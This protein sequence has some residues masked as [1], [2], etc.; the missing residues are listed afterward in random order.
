MG[1]RK[2]VFAIAI[3]VAV[4]AAALIWRLRSDPLR[5]LVKLVGQRRVTEAR[6]SGGFD[7]AP[8][9]RTAIRA[10]IATR[11][12]SAPRVRGEEQTRASVSHGRSPND[13]HAA[14]MATLLFGDRRRAVTRFEQLA[15]ENPGDPQ[16]W[17]DLAAAR[18][19]A[20]VEASDASLVAA[21]LAAA[22]AALRLDSAQPEA[23]FNR[24]VAIEHLGIREEARK[25]WMRFLAVDGTSPWAAEAQERIRRTPPIPFFLVDL[26]VHYDRL[27][28][29]AAFAHK[30]ARE[31]PEET[32]L[33]SE[34][35]ILADWAAAAAAG[36]EEAAE[37][38]LG[39]AREFGRE[40]ARNRGD[41]MV[42][43]AVRAVEDADDGQRQHLIRGHTLFR[44]GQN[45][46]K[47][48]R[49]A[50]AQKILER[51]ADDL[52]QGGSP[53]RL[54]A[55]F[56]LAHTFDALGNVAEARRRELKLLADA[57][58]EF[59]AHRA[60]LLWYLGI[61]Y[62]SDGDFG[63]A[64]DVLGESVTIFDDLGEADYAAAVR[65]LM[66]E[67][68]D[69]NGNP[70]EA[71]QQH[72]VSL[73]GVGRLI[74]PRL[75]TALQNV[76]RGAMMRKD[77]PVAL[78]FLH[79]AGEM[80]V[81]VGRPTIEAEVRL[82]QARAFAETRNRREARA[83]LARAREA[84]A[85]IDDEAA[86]RESLIDI[87]RSEAMLTASPKVAVALLTRAIDFHATHG[88]RIVLP[89]LYLARGRA[90]RDD[91]QPAL[92]AADFETGIAQVEKH[93]QS[94]PQG[95]LRWGTFDTAAELFEQAVAAAIG[96][97]D[98]AAAFNYAERSRARTLLETLGAATPG[99]IPASF[100]HDTALIEYFSLPD[101]LLIFVVSGGGLRV[102]EE[103]IE[104][105]LLEQEAAAFRHA[106]AEGSPQ[107]RQLGASLYRRL[108]A[109]IER[110]VGASQ[111]LVFV[112][113]LHFPAVSFAALPAGP[114]YL[115][116]RH[117]ILVSPSAAVYAHLAS[118][119][120]GTAA[121][122]T[123][124]VIANP[125]NDA[126]ALTGAEAEANDVA[127]LYAH[128]RLL[129]RD[130]ATFE[131]YRRFAP[132]ADVIHMGT[133]GRESTRRGAGALLLSDG[134]LDSKTIASIELPHTRAVVLAAC[135]SA[136]GPARAEG[137]I[138]AARGFLA[139]GVPAVVATL[140][141]IDDGRAAQFFPRLHR[142]LARGITASS[143]VRAAQIESIER[144]ESPA[145]WA[146]VQC[147]GG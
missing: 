78:S 8:L 59:R 6:L 73:R 105:T 85:K 32:R 107:H 147:I 119:K 77:W 47:F 3:M 29:D 108:I 87:D 126:G 146:A 72:L 50:A 71:W 54:L 19:E 22:D 56:F 21:A 11:S 37:R 120:R 116:H 74:Q 28:S 143:A 136:R 26:R 137:T 112:P 134:M 100:A 99:V 145:L 129:L 103:R 80:A 123:A 70:E 43:Q 68:H 44:E 39:I 46:L 124:L 106:L 144:G 67:V 57:P 97:G 2:T 61:G 86:R 69:R 52:G 121:R 138:S 45:E 133:H 140:W 64:L 113:G 127:A 65:Q 83:S 81:T 15:S 115:V 38:H 42:Q 98:A 48:D 53:V 117:E 122:L 75:A 114:K 10:P 4:L 41:F 40:L 27:A 51:A 130:E 118:R 24:A 131:A 125:A 63:K 109:P 17:N 9:P 89:E 82:L 96:R 18:Y 49:A 90:Y 55:E 93:R 7:W 94:L 84:T 5:Q 91:G 20:G 76:G 139:A 35:V 30:M 141:K 33:Y 34:T 23:L 111:T 60:Q 95:E 36:R 79:L 1:R 88:R 110:E 128:S 12:D 132:A 31:R 58:R 92:A 101:R 142:D 25:A 62:Q 14:A 66:A 16:L 102:A 13:D 135:D 104:R